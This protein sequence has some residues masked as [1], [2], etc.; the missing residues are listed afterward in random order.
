MNAAFYFL[1]EAGMYIS[2]LVLDEYRFF[3][4]R[5]NRPVDL[6]S[7]WANVEKHRI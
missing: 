3:G 1:I 5:I 4:K 7:R 6:D 2:W